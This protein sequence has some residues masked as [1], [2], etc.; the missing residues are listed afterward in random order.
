[1]N[2]LAKSK[3]KSKFKKSPKLNI[4]KIIVA[5]AG[6]LV[7]YLSLH[8]GHAISLFF[9]HDIDILTALNHFAFNISSNPAA[10]ITTLGHPA[11][12]GTVFAL[13]I[14]GFLI[15][16]MQR[17]KRKSFHRHKTEHGSA[18]FLKTD[19]FAHLKDPIDS[20]NLI[21]S[22]DIRLSTDHHKTGVNLNIWI[23]GGLGSGKT[24]GFLKPNILNLANKKQGFG[25]NMVITDAKGNILKTVG[26]FLRKKGYKIKVLNLAEISKSDYYN[27]FVYMNAGKPEEVIAIIET[28]IQSTNIKEDSPQGGGGS[29][30]KFWENAEKMLL[31]ALFFYILEAEPPERQSIVTLLELL[32]ENVISDKDDNPLSRR[33][34]ALEAKNPSSLALSFWKKVGAGNVETMRTVVTIANARFS[35]F[36]G[37]K[38]MFS[39]DTLEINK[40]DDG[41]AAY[42]VTIDPSNS[43]LSF[44]ATIFYTQMFQV[45]VH[46]ATIKNAAK[47]GMAA[48]EPSLSRQTMFLLDEFANIPKIPNFL[49]M[50]GISRS[51]NIGLVPIFQS[52]VQAKKMYGDEWEIIFDSCDCGIYLGGN[53][54]NFA[55]KYISEMLGKETVDMKV[56][57]ISYDRGKKYNT[58]A[59]ALGRELMT[60]DE[61]GRMKKSDSIV[62]FS[63][64]SPILTTKYNLTDHKYYKELADA[65]KGD[66]SFIY[67]HYVPEWDISQKYMVE[68]DISHI[69]SDDIDFVQTEIDLYGEHGELFDQPQRAGIM[70]DEL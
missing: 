42:F 24:R 8:L 70:N 21:L 40:I 63:F 26:K 14:I 66:N 43:A 31:Q 27:P 46:T 48:I 12:L 56:T 65:N 45:L 41:P 30:D 51:L 20:K 17:D 47:G 11:T 38:H 13:G 52:I 49:K 28:L 5:T 35:L 68:I 3:S 22:K 36:S 32:D 59:S 33:F 16:A 29:N 2:P 64:E 9:M 61:L 69:W 60:A 62:K 39:K 1:V 58:Q 53:Q 7:L 34:L 25:A 50:L 10:F 44:I 6:F 18:K 57:S 37:I 19:A 15:F 67:E 4:T 23:I 54:S 55:T